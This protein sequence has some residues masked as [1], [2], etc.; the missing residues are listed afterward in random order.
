[1]IKVTTS[2]SDS[3][4]R[5]WDFY[6][7]YRGESLIEGAPPITTLP[8][9]IKAPKQHVIDWETAGLIYGKVLDVGCGLGDN[10]IYLAAKGH[11]VTG[12]D[13][14]PTALTIAEERAKEAGMKIRFEVADAAKL[15][16]Y[17]AAFDTVI[18]SGMFHCLD[19][20]HKR[21]YAHALHR[22]TRA[23]ARLLLCCFSDANVA[24]PDGPLPVVSEATLHGSLG[25]AGWDITSLQGIT[26]P[27]KNAE[28]EV[29]VRWPFGSRLS[30]AF[31]LAQAE[32]R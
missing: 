25:D 24:D 30:L 32:R 28:G 19:D 9:D 18:D 31:W 26:R 3:P 23:G 13:I 2:S 1:M 22:A 12:L 10:A 15:D 7:Q 17:A 14:S 11:R 4:A 27:L 21:A 29:E 8:W 5:G 20:E 6:A 16:G